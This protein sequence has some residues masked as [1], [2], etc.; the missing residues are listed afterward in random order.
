MKSLTTL[1]RITIDSQ[2]LLLL[3]PSHVLGHRCIF[4]QRFFRDKTLGQFLFRN[5]IVNARMALAADLDSARSHLA[6]RVPL[7]KTLLPMHRLGNQMVERERFVSPTELAAW[8]AT[9]RSL[10]S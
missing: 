3:H 1:R 6:L 7:L 4:Q 9:V 8:H 2:S 10:Y 5:Q